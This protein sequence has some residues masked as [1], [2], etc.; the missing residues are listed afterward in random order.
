MKTI[1]IPEIEKEI[2]KIKI[3]LHT[4]HID[5]EEVDQIK[6]NMTSYKEGFYDEC[7]YAI[8]EV[9]SKWRKKYGLY[10][11]IMDGILGDKSPEWGTQLFPPIQLCQL[12]WQQHFRE[13]MQE[14]FFALVYAMDTLRRKN[15]K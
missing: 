10:E 15:K 9:F 13:E 12:N 3:A 6:M 4:M 11:E 2:K 1:E 8:N 7:L 14:D 5:D